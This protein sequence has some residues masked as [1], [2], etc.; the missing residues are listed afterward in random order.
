MTVHPAAWNARTRSKSPRHCRLSVRCRSPSYSRST[1]CWTYARSGSSGPMRVCTTK[2]ICGSGSLAP[3]SSSRSSVSLTESTPV[4]MSGSASLSAQAPRPR[5]W[6]RTAAARSFTVQSGSSRPYPRVRFPVTSASPAATRLEKGMPGARA[7]CAAS[8]HHAVA[9][10]T[11]I[12]PSGVS[13]V[14]VAAG[15]WWPVIPRRRTL[16]LPIVPTWIGSFGMVSSPGSGTPQSS[17]AVLPTNGWL[18]PSTTAA[19]RQREI[20]SPRSSTTVRTP[21]NGAA[22]SEARSLLLVTPNEGASD[23]AKALFVRNSGSGRR[24][25]IHRASR[26]PEGPRPLST[27]P[28]HTTRCAGS[29]AASASRHSS[30]VRRPSTVHN[31][32]LEI[33]RP[34]AAV[35]SAAGRP[36]A[37]ARRS[38]RP[39]RMP[40]PFRMPRR[41]R[42]RPPRCPRSGAQRSCPAPASAAPAGHRARGRSAGRRRGRHPHRSSRRSGRSIGCVSV[43]ARTP[44]GE[45]PSTSPMRAATVTG[46]LYRSK[47]CTRT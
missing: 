26:A 1:R 36:A 28:R 3:I 30:T 39:H 8:S 11:V 47:A 16:P 24:A 10:S 37:D 17:S 29:A 13:A 35:S 46:S 27:A 42:P 23:A 32:R 20:G 40:R 9:G 4:L 22:T 15:S 33:R 25:F 12:S 19:A 5:P 6:S 38:V 34:V 18:S 14:L 31:R 2:P 44:C 7:S 43:S 45:M 21:W 41:G